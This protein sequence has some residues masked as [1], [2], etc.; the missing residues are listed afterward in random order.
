[1]SDFY[2]ACFGKAVVNNSVIKM[3][4]KKPLTQKNIMEI[5]QKHRDEIKSYKT[6]KIGL[7]GSF[8]KGSGDEKSDIDFLVAFSEPTFDNYMGL[9]FFLEELFG[10]K[11]DLVIAETL[12]P[13]LQYV[14]KEAVYAEG[15]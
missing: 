11:I 10:R 5:L 7:F 4:D 14:K 1:M 15:I 3:K 13:A 9:K 2:I 12:K 6:K 8:L